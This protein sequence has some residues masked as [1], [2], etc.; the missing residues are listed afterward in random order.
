MKKIFHSAFIIFCF[1]NSSMG[2]NEISP[3]FQLR[4]NANYNIGITQD[5]EG[6]IWIGTANG[7]VKYDGYNL[8]HFQ[9]EDGLSSNIAPVLYTDSRGLIWIGT[10]G[11][12]LNVYDKRD[13]SFTVYRHDPEDPETISSDSFLWAVDQITEDGDGNI[14]AGTANGLNR[15]DRETGRFTRYFHDPENPDSLS[16]NEV[17][18]VT[19]DRDGLIWTATRNGLSRY[20]KRTDQFT[21]FYHDPD[22]ENSLS[23]NWVYSVYEDGE[24]YIW[25][26][27]QNGGLNRFDKRRAMFRRYSHDPDDAASLHHNEVFFIR[28]DPSG[29][30]W[31]GR[32]YSNPIGL[33]RFD[34]DRQAFALYSHDPE[35]PDSLPGNFVQS[36]L[37][38]RSGIL[39]IV[40]DLGPVSTYDKNLQKFHKFNHD[41]GGAKGIPS[42]NLTTLLEAG[43]GRIW[44]GTVDGG[45]IRYNKEDQSFTSFNADPEQPGGLPHDYVYSLIEGTDGRLWIG[46]DGGWLCLFN[47]ETGLV[48][49]RYSIPGSNE[50]PQGLIRDTLNPDWLWFGTG[51]N[52]LYRFSI[53]TAEFRQFVH[54]SGVESS[55]PNNSVGNLLQ[56]E[57]GT[58]WISTLGGGLAR[59]NREDLTFTTFVHSEDDPDSIGSNNIRD[60]RIRANGEFWITTSGGGLNRFDRDKNSFTRYTVKNGLPTDTLFSIEEDD[61]SKLWLTSDAGLVKF[62]PAAG[63]VENTFTKEDGLQGD[64]FNFFPSSSLRTRDGL[65]WVS[66]NNGVN[67]FRPESIGTNDYIP[68]VYL[69]SVKQNGLEMERSSAPELMTE[70]TLDWR[71]NYFEFEF[72]ALNYTLSNKN[73]YA[74]MLEGVDR[75]WYF[76]EQRRFGRFSAIPDGTHELRIKAANN[77]GLWNEQGTS[78]LITVEPPFWR[79]L[80]FRLAALLSLILFISLM[81]RYRVRSIGKRNELLEKRI[82]EKTLELRNSNEKLL[83]LTLTDALTGLN[84]RRYLQEFI[85]D[86]ISYINRIHHGDGPSPQDGPSRLDLGFLLLDL[87]NFKKVN[88]RYGHKIGDDVLKNSARI[89][90]SVCRESDRIMRWGGE[91]FL[92]VSKGADNNPE[93][94]AQ[95]ILEAFRMTPTPV[96]DSTSITT[97][98]SIGI[99]SYPFLPD[100]GIGWE[101]TVIMADKAL[102]SAKLSGRNGWVRLIGIDNKQGTRADIATKGLTELLKSGEVE[103]RSSFDTATL[104]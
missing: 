52:G 48:E 58:I 81:V 78:L 33:E 8:I 96:D 94:L 37:F 75:E 54:S 30:L 35:N 6:F 92:I 103:L 20:D 40:D 82:R 57:N 50:A 14:W 22:S 49:R 62:D 90:R 34:R 9:E 71:E 104:L 15:F 11:G 86:E 43:S 102:Y 64:V 95:R 47:P 63:A 17:W 4:F 51:S 70:L 41:P 56:D 32:S 27:T 84:N 73:S 99:A 42:L 101:Q 46:T 59:L 85:E 31:L 28:E 61:D 16:H 3:R 24:G 83:N 21:N 76:S 26:G 87:D 7:I 88:D 100:D 55:L 13:D 36:F 79:T 12:G 10:A 18:A 44:I 23:D 2:A 66:G 97:T 39:W 60:M 68:P 72:S 93:V 1:I 53:G 74:Y 89:L 98:C 80:A 65:I 5:R 91:E 19:A 69:T 77:D 38:D 45:L 29:D 67:T 25:A